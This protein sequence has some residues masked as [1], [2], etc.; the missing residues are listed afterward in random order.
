[1]NGDGTVNDSEADTVTEHDQSY[2]T[3]DAVDEVCGYFC[4]ATCDIFPL[5]LYETLWSTIISN[6]VS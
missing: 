4:G 1:M 2:T 6:Q 3:E 5:K